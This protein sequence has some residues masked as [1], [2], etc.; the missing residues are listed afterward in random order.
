M[1]FN[2]NNIMEKIASFNIYCFLTLSYLSSY[3]YAQVVEVYTE[4]LPPFQTFS[5]KEVSGTATE[6]VK[7]ILY[8]SNLN[9]QFHM[10]P[11][12]RAFQKAKQQ[13][14]TL[15]YSM[16]RTAEREPFFH[17]LTVVAQIKNGFIALKENQIKLQNLEK[18]KSYITAVVRD[19][20]AYEYL[21]SQGF[22]EDKNLLVVG[23]REAQLNVFLS[24]KVDFLFL[25]LSY[26]QEKLLANKLSPSLIEHVF[27]QPDWARELYLAIN[28]NSDEKIINK[29]K[30]A[31]ASIEKIP[32]P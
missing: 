24:G 31:I 6:K 12:A 7:K 11:W 15:I 30:T 26:L 3:A 17:W 16:H 1:I 22:T 13:Q 20:Y 18:A 14:N 29:L 27:T 9:A 10:V 5:K 8:S 19:S 25:D 32:A 21:K 23:S 4:L 28:K 2:D